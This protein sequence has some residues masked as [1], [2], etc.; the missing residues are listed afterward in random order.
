MK[1]DAENTARHAL[2]HVLA[3]MMKSYDE[4][5]A[6]ETHLA[7]AVV[8]LQQDADLSK[9]DSKMIEQI[10]RCMTMVTGKKYE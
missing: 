4:P 8:I 7:R 9:F 1:P 2:H 5:M 3:G 6:A 10:K